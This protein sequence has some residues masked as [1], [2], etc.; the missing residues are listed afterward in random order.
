MIARK[1]T[2]RF[3]TINMCSDDA[4]NR[5]VQNWL[6]ERRI[7]ESS[8]FIAVSDKFP[9]SKGHTLIFSKRPVQDIFELTAQDF[10]DLQGILAD[11]RS[12]L[13]AELA[14]DGFN[15]GTNSGS[16]A[17][18]TVMRFHLHVIPRF[19]GD[20]KDP[21]GGIRNLKSSDVA[22]PAKITENR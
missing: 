10:A 15:V 4:T 22:Y 9:V 2:I 3:R 11:V 14:P 16:A 5:V 6:D 17:G 21:T 1:A 20:V 19:V 8:G 7:A 18:Q 12:K 13:M